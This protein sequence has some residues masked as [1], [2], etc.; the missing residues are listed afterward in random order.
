MLEVQWVLQFKLHALPSGKGSSQLSWQKLTKLRCFL[1]A[2]LT[3]LW[4]CNCRPPPTQQTQAS[5]PGHFHPAPESRINREKSRDENWN[6]LYRYVKTYVNICKCVKEALPSNLS[7]ATVRGPCRTSRRP[8]MPIHH[9]IDRSSAL[10]FYLR[11]Y[12]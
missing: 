3:G 6:P 1:W 5:S 2:P 4:Q 12:L 8:A 9:S 7:M 11:L 10:T